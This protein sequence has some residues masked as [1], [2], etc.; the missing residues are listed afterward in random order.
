MDI[1]Y[2]EALEEALE[3]QASLS[4]EEF[5]KWAEEQIEKDAGFWSTVIG[6]GMSLA[7]KAGKAFGN[8]APKV[9]NAA[10]GV[11]KAFS[12]G[13]GATGGEAAGAALSGLGK[14][15][16]PLAI[17]G[18]ALMA[19]NAIGKGIGRGMRPKQQQDDQGINQVA[20]S[21]SELLD[22]MEVL[23]NELSEEEF[24]KATS[25][26]MEKNAGL[27]T[28]IARK[29]G[30]W[31]AN[32]EARTAIKGAEKAAKREAQAGFQNT[33]NDAKAALKKKS[34]D[35]TMAKKKN[36]WDLK[37]APVPGPQPTPYGEA[38]RGATTEAGAAGATEGAAGNA[39]K[40]AKPAKDKKFGLGKKIKL[41]GT[42]AAIGGIGAGIIG[43]SKKKKTDDEQDQGMPTYASLIEDFEKVAA[44]VDEETRESIALQILEDLGMI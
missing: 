8:V 41:L 10:K 1:R 39:G 7:N 33:V 38:A 35:A 44:Q 14:V 29:A 25:E 15:V 32:A 21:C 30:Q 3:K 36:L 2:R 11:G 28:D 12:A 34:L 31:G 37:G 19:A 6:K 4:P 23:A 20:M 27:I 24:E 5:E 16:K 26:I 42:G 9:M 43:S 18:G 40:A 13:A 17:G 22:Y